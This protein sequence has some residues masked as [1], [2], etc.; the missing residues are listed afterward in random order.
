MSKVKEI[1]ENGVEK[2]I[3]EVTPD[4]KLVGTFYDKKETNKGV[5]LLPGFTE[6]RSSLDSLAEQLS[7]DFRVWTFDLNSQGESTGFWNLNEMLVS[8]YIVHDKLKERY[9]LKQVGTHG[10][11]LGGMVA[12]LIAYHEPELINA[13]CLTSTPAGLQDIVPKSVRTIMKK[14]PQSW[15]RTGTIL[16]DMF[17]SGVNSAY[18]EKTHPQFRT[19]QGYQQYA[20]FGATKI[21]SIRKMMMGIE[22]AP[23]LDTIAP[24]INQPTLLVYG[25]EDKMLGIKGSKVPT[26]IQRMI[27][28]FSKGIWMVIADADHSLNTK[29]Q[30]DG[31]FN[32]DQKYQFVRKHVLHHFKHYLL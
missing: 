25:G 31:C 4:I 2:T 3:V 16:F 15:V 23:R 28:S 10:N 30:P 6:H 19:E 5:V 11:S 21:P 18:R 13:L 20:Q 17:Q 14:T 7:S 9:G 8:F 29:T 1:K 12:G 27:D 26:R 22:R 32:Q 24:E